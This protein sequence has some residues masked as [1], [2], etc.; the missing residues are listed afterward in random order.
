MTEYKE[1]DLL[2]TWILK[3]FRER[4]PMKILFPSNYN[5]LRQVD[6]S[7]QLE[8][9][10]ILNIG[11]YDVISFQQRDRDCGRLVLSEQV[12]KPA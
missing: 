8:Y 4:H 2:Q 7:Y 3:F 1:F 10:A 12:E 5:N 9:E 6:P 11:F